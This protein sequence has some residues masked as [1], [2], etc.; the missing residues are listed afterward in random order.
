LPTHAGRA[1]FL[2]TEGGLEKSVHGRVRAKTK[3]EA[4]RPDGGKERIEYF[5]SKRFREGREVYRSLGY[6]AV[7]RMNAFAKELGLSVTNNDQ[8][9]MFLTWMG[10][11]EY[12]FLVKGGT[13]SDLNGRNR[14]V[15]RKSK[16]L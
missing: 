7:V 16:P 10:G 1:R 14:R 12:P 9:Y 5:K 8:S 2:V 3:P 13:D 11:Q 4:E 6:F 15:A